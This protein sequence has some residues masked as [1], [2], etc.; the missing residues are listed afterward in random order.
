MKIPTKLQNLINQDTIKKF[1]DGVNQTNNKNELNKKVRTVFGIYFILFSLLIIYLGSFMFFDDIDFINSPL[2]PRITA[3]DDSIERGDIYTS[4]FV[5][6]T[7][8][9]GNTLYPF[10]SL[11]AH[12]VGYNNHGVAGVESWY[13]LV[14]NDLDNEVIQRIN[15]I[16]YGKTPKGNSVVLSINHNLQSYVSEKLEDKKGSILVMNPSNGEIL[17]MVSNPTF[18]PNNLEDT[19]EEL[20]NDEDAPFINRAT[21]GVYPPASTFKPISEL[22]FMRNVSDY[23]DYTYISDGDITLDGQTITEVGDHAYGELDLKDAL[24][25]SS[26]TFFA[27]LANEITPEQLEQTAN[28]IGF[29]KH[30]PADFNTAVSVFNTPKDSEFLQTLIGQGTI[31]MSPL[32][33]GLFYSAIANDGVVYKP[34]IAKEVYNYKSEKIQ[35]YSPEKIA[36]IM[37]KDEADYIESTLEDV[38]KIGT[39][40]SL[41]SLP[42]DIIAKTGTAQNDQGSDHGWF[43]GYADQVDPEVLV[44]IMYENIGGSHY[45]IDDAYDIFEYYYENTPE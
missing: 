34:H 42:F 7:D 6:L 10:G 16:L 2:N 32:H 31:Q 36:T 27:S 19:Y 39:A 5:Q 1:N 44:V 24:T 23:D 14:L 22:A 25:Y 26:N 41:S 17:A 9:T 4:D 29:N 13:S 45:T 30:I 33:L 12:T 40:S 37:T 35:T 18:D 3:T 38:T 43:V 20:S 28:D 15:A 8:R 11:Y 21:Q